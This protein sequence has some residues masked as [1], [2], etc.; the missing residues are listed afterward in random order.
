[1]IEDLKANSA[2]WHSKWH[3]QIP[4]TGFDDDFDNYCRTKTPSYNG[5]EGDFNSLP[6]NSQDS[7]EAVVHCN[8]KKRYKSS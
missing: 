8:Y 2:R 7:W 3:P 5:A 6:F 1:M 4:Q